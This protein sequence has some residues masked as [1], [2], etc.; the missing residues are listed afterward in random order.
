MAR[1]YCAGFGETTIDSRDLQ[2]QSALPAGRAI[3]AV[4]STWC[5]AAAAAAAPAAA[6]VALAVPPQHPL[7]TS[8]C[9]GGCRTLTLA[10]LPAV[11][12]V[13]AGQ[14]QAVNV[15]RVLALAG[16]GTKNG[17]NA[18]GAAGPAAAIGNM[19][20]AVAVGEVAENT[21]QDDDATCVAAR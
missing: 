21:C 17:D 12:L 14:Q 13:A 4:A 2:C 5:C 8:C 6:A 11:A 19:D 7:A 16:E 1:K 18:N 3:A 15:A 20:N 10:P 9:E